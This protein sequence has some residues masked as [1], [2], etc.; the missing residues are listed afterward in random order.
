MAVLVMHGAVSVLYTF[1]RLLPYV[2]WWDQY[3]KTYITYFW[4]YTDFILKAYSFFHPVSYQS[5]LCSFPS[6]L[7]EQLAGA[8]LNWLSWTSQIFPVS[9]THSR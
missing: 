8:L 5:F 6:R 9:V 2:D 7:Y 1:N 4:W 3:P